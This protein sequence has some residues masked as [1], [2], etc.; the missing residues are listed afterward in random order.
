MDMEVERAPALPP[1]RDAATVFRDLFMAH[2]A[3]VFHSLRRFGVPERDL[4]DVTHDVFVVVH[5]KLAE[6]DATRPP[7]PWLCAIA[8]RVAADY[9]R[10]ARH[11]REQIGEPPEQVDHAPSA[12]A[13]LDTR[14]AQALVIEALQS[15]DESRRAVFVMIDL[16]GAGAPEAAHALQVPLNTV[17]S[18]L[19]L[20]RAEFAAAV[21]RLQLQRGAR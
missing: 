15:I 7:K 8:A 16:D 18:R 12:D 17:Y 11:R 4:E 13:Q 1:R 3:Y 5:R 20:A 19:R 21:R 6:Y 9:R 14:A 2:G 10:L